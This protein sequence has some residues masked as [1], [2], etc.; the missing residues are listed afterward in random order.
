MCF[1]CVFIGSSVSH[2][3]LE[4]W[5][6]LSG[7]VFPRVL[8]LFGFFC[9]YFWIVCVFKVRFLL[10]ALTSESV[11]FLVCY[12]HTNPL[13]KPQQLCLHETYFPFTA[14]HCIASLRCRST[15]WEHNKNVQIGVQQ[16]FVLDTKHF[17]R[18]DNINLAIK[19]SQWFSQNVVRPL[20]IRY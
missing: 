1:T 2:I 17:C 20:N 16:M 8:Y 18:Y 14:C 3:S 5:N 12:L 13:Y 6:I 10:H 15:D 9:L 11:R 7:T 19:V 4:G